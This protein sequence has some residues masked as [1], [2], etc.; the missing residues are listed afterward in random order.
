MLHFFLEANGE[1][2]LGSLAVL[3]PLT[4]WLISIVWAG[5]SQY[6]MF[7]EQQATADMFH[8]QGR[9]EHQK[10]KVQAAPVGSEEREVALRHAA[11]FHEEADAHH[12]DSRRWLKM[13]RISLRFSV[14]SFATGGLWSISA[15]ALKI[16][17]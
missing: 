5:L 17:H 1:V 6:G 4:A 16:L 8:A 7:E 11:N 13:R 9:R 12:R 2:R 3:P 14:G 15:L 10:A